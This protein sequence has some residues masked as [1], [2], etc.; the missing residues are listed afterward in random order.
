[1]DNGYP[2]IDMGPQNSGQKVVWRINNRHCKKTSSEYNR[3]F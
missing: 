1:M 3:I 2:C